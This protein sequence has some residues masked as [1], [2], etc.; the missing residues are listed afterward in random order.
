MRSVLIVNVSVPVLTFIPKVERAECVHCKSRIIHG[1]CT[2][3]NALPKKSRFLIEQLVDMN[4][5]MDKYKTSQLGQALKSVYRGEM[6]INQSVEIAQ[7]EILEVFNQKVEEG[8]GF[9]GE[10]IG[11]CPICKKRVVRGS[12]AYGCEGAKE[13][14]EFRMPFKILGTSISKT[15]AKKLLETGFTDKLKFISKQGKEFESRLK[16][17]KDNKIVFDF[18]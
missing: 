13:G 16:L 9:Y 7:R 1:H 6:T 18:N 15:Q 4:I 2:P 5:S 8:T 10:E 11:V 14:C 17:D 12:F 3:S